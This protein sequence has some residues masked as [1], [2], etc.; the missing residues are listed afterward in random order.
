M[1]TG[2]AINNTIDCIQI[3]SN[4]GIIMIQKFCFKLLGTH[5]IKVVGTLPNQFQYAESTFTLIG[6]G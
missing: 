1:S 4:S 3:N 6:V 2:I 5:T